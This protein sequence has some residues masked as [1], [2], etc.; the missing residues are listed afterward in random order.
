MVGGD[1]KRALAEVVRA[2]IAAQAKLEH[3]RGEETAM[4]KLVNAARLMRE[5][6]GLAELKKLALLERAAEGGG[7]T[8][9]LG[10]DS[11]SGL[12]RKG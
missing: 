11:A 10:L 8:L 1:L 12:A 6:E 4:R 7:N 5:H 3:A 2:R 9:V